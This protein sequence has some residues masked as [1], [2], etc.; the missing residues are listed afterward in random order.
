LKLAADGNTRLVAGHKDFPNAQ[1]LAMQPDGGDVIWLGS[2]AGLIAFSRNQGKLAGKRS[3]S[4]ADSIFHVAD[5]S[6]GN[7]W[8]TTRAG[9][10]TVRKDA[11][12][13]YLSGLGGDPP[14]IRRYG[15]A[16][17]L[18]CLNFGLAASPAGFRD[19]QG[20]IWLASLKGLVRFQP[21]QLAKPHQ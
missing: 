6:A 16:E 20:N 15:A 10:L 1:W 5:D 9:I 13:R 2:S 18:P 17:G 14:E 7:L 8:L 12:L 19:P 4:P 11:A 21:A 3:L